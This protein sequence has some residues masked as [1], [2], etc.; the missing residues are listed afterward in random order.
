MCAMCTSPSRLCTC[1][2]WPTNRATSLKT[3]R[4]WGCSLSLYPFLDSLLLSFNFVKLNLFVC[5]IFIYFIYFLILRLL[6]SLHGCRDLLLLI[7][8]C[9]WHVH[10]SHSFTSVWCIPF[11]SPFILGT[12]SFINIIWPFPYGCID[13]PPIET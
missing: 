12:V 1:C 9:A 11:F 8:F 7:L 5:F 10:T 6:S 3:W 2:L 13:R 4:L